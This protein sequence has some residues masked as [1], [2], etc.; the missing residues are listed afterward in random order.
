MVD[1]SEIFSLLDNIVD[2]SDF[3]RS[4]L[5]I[6][7]VSAIFTLRLILP[8]KALAV[9]IIKLFNLVESA[10]SLARI[11]DTLSPKAAPAELPKL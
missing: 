4:T 3:L 8:V 2:V 10:L 5:N 1:V 11:D 9:S 7:E 6:D